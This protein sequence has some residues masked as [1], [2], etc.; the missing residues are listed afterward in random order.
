MSTTTSSLKMKLLVDT[1]ANR[2]FFAEADK[3]V[4]DFLFSLLALPVATIVEMLGTSSMH[5]SFGNLYGSV[6]KLDDTYVLPGAKK[7]AVLQPTV[8][9]SAARSLLLPAPPSSSS[10]QQYDL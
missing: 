7:E 2:V 6:E 10:D 8:V 4:V 5:G 9:A 3:G 1:T